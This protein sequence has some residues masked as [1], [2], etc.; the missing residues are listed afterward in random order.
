MTLM[1]KYGDAIYL[2]VNN[3]I[4]I[5]RLKLAAKDRPIVL[6]KNEEELRQYVAELRLKCEHHYKRAK[7]II[8]GENPDLEMVADLLTA[9]N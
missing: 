5:S 3:D 8:D 2:N 7:Y 1:E 6:G 4:L 9:G